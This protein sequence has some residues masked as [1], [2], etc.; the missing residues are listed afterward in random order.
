LFEEELEEVVRRI[1][2]AGDSRTAM[3]EEVKGFSIER[4]SVIP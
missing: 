1:E 2:E 3:P 4:S